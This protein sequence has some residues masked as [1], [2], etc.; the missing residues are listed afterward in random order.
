MSAK[1]KEL[2][3][4]KARQAVVRKEYQQSHADQTWDFTS[5]SIFIRELEQLYDDIK[6]LEE[7][8]ENPMP[9]RRRV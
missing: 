8:T 7:E 6:R 2:E 3:H 9:G 1:R 4:L 5:D